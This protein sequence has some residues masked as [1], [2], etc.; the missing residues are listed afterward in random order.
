[1]IASLAGRI[2]HKIAM[3]LMLTGDEL[4][5]QRAYDVGLVNRLVPQ[6]QHL[7]EAQAWA[8]RMAKNSPMVMGMLKR[9]AADVLPKGPVEKSSFALR[10][11]DAIAGSADFLEGLSSLRE[12]RAP[13]FRGE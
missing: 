8:R 11:A 1:M 9:F 5:A 12:K 4:A 7:V 10:E 3:E 2:P 6:G 13:T